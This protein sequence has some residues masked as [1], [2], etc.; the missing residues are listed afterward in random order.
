MNGVRVLMHGMTL[1]V[2][3]IGR[4]IQCTAYTKHTIKR[5][6]QLIGSMPCTRIVIT[7]IAP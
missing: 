1:S 7:Y 6:D 4:V 2:T 3:D 5:A